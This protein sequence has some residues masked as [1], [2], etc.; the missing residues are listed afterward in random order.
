MKELITFLL[1]VSGIYKKDLEFTLKSDRNNPDEGLAVVSDKEYIVVIMDGFERN[2]CLY[3]MI[4]SSETGS[5]PT[6]KLLVA[7]K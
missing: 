3:E 1:P 2:Y 5:K 7:P 4:L 6:D